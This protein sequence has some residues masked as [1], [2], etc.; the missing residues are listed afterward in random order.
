[1]LVR[2]QH[3]LFRYCY[4]IF[5]TGLVTLVLLQSSSQPVVGPAAPPGHPTLEREIFL[6]TGHIIAFSILSLLWWW[7]FIS[8]LPMI[9]SLIFSALIALPL[10]LVT[11][12]LQTLVPDRSASLFD[13]AVN[14]I[15]TLLT[16]YIIH[17]V[18]TPTLKHQPA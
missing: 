10:G 15:V 17:Q 12:I 14:M 1:M 13:L 7:A 16:L 2:L 6:T 18:Y 8:R 3:P 5:W 11:E 4:A 9:K